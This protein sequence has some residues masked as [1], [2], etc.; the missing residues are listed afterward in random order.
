MSNSTTVSDPAD[1]VE[2]L[3]D[4]RAERHDARVAL[5]DVSRLKRLR[6]CGRSAVT[7]DGSVA[8]RVSELDGRRVAGFAGVATCGSVWACP[9]CSAKIA[10]HR[11]GEVE[12]AARAWESIGG[13]LGF[14][15]LTVKHDRGQSLEQVWA[16]VRDGWHSITSNRRW[17][18]RTCKSY[19]IEGWTRVVEVKHGEHGWH[20]HVHAVLYL[21]H[22][23]RLAELK[24]LRAALYGR[25][26]TGI[27]KHGFSAANIV[28]GPDG[29]LQGVGCDVRELSGEDVVSAVAG[30][31]TKQ[32]QY[33]RAELVAVEVA[34]GD[35]KRGRGGRSPFEILADFVRSGDTADLALWH[36]W[37]KVSKG[38][39][40]MTWS[41]GLRQLVGLL[42]DEMS[43]EAIAAD[44]LGDQA[45]DVV[46]LPDE[47]WRK[48][49]RHSW[50]ILDM[51]ETVDVAAFRYWLDRVGIEWRAPG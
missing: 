3:R 4:R 26:S 51:A 5:W 43:D 35:L 36:E 16:A 10:A 44:E 48:V 30:Y 14:V 33:T 19:G 47:S 9:V 40:Q 8:V 22:R 7:G 46:V 37:E 29:R 2:A 34:R 32:S 49:R 39:R 11:Q 31:L 18:E 13:V 28:R 27:G 17:W 38:R 20:V 1:K 45:D 21:H 23:L 50:L 25:W 41:K 6:S 42:V 12:Q 24:G 15:T